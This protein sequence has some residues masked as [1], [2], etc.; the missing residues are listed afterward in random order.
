MENIIDV[1]GGNINKIE[2][3]ID[4]MRTFEEK[5]EHCCYAGMKDGEE[6]SEHRCLDCDDNGRICLYV[7]CDV[8]TEKKLVSGMSWMAHDKKSFDEIV[9]FCDGLIAIFN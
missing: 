4:V 3:E 2:L 9:G 7:H 6:G 1:L 5:H 8:H